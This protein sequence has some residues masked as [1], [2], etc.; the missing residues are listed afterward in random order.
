MELLTILLNFIFGTTPGFFYL[1]N[2]IHQTVLGGLADSLGIHVNVLFVIGL[3]LAVLGGLLAY[4]FVKAFLA[5]FAAGFGFLIG[6]RVYFCVQTETMP[7]WV[8]YL[9]G[10]VLA[11]F[12]FCLAYGRASYVWYVMASLAGYWVTWTYLEKDF[13]VALG[14]AFVLAMLSIAL[15]RVVYIL[16]TS[17]GCGVL[18]VSFLSPLLPNTGFL[19]LEPKN[20][21]FWVTALAV[22]AIFIV[23]QCLINRLW[24]KRKA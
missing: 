15:F 19:R 2:S 4:R 24:K 11:I 9:F 21:G 22:S 6:M 5:L 1:L 18:T 3:C 16:F 7:Y 14:G 13:L 23:A 8:C 12:F 17:L 10:A 20:F